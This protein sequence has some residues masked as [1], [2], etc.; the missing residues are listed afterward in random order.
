MNKDQINNL[1]ILLMT[2]GISALFFS[3]IHQFLM[4]MFLSGLFSALARPFYLRLDLWLGGRH[5]LASLVTLLAMV[6]TMCASHG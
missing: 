4:V 5:H 6:F 3:M 1:T 2:L